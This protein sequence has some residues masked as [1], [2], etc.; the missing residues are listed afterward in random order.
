MLC[1]NA[2]LLNI[3]PDRTMSHTG[4]QSLLPF[5]STS[6]IN[7]G[8]QYSHSSDCLSTQSILSRTRSS[9]AVFAL[10]LGHRKFNINIDKLTYPRS[11]AVSRTALWSVLSSLGIDLMYNLWPTVKIEYEDPR[12]LRV[13]TARRISSLP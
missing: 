6:N 4:A 7:P 2:L 9:M 5:A 12:G 13:V 8:L 11:C 3:H 10:A 1:A